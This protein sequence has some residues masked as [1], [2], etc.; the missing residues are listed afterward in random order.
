LP[1][2]ASPP[3]DT[4]DTIADPVDYEHMSREEFIKFSIEN[5]RALVREVSKE[6]QAN[7]DR[8]L[9]SGNIE[10]LFPPLT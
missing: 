4:T 2:D 1:P 6:A 7:V 9:A 10:D 5:H 3:S 8:Y